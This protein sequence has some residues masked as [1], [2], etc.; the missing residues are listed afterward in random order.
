MIEVLFPA[1]GRPN[2]SE[3]RRRWGRLKW[4]SCVKCFHR[5]HVPGELIASAAGSS[6]PPSDMSTVA[7]FDTK[8]AWSV[9]GRSGGLSPRSSAVSA[10]Q[11][12]LTHEVLNEISRVTV[13]NIGR[14][15]RGEPALPASVL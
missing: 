2:P 13:E 4:A 10:H 5:C 11:A 7:F 3:R 15:A 14:C 12:F 9:P 8:S 6:S 1:A